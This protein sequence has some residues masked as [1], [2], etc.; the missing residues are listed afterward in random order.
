MVLRG[1]GPFLST[2]KTI[3]A[4]LQTLN[5]FHSARQR[6]I[7]YS[8]FFFLL[9]FFLNTIIIIRHCKLSIWDGFGYDTITPFHS[10]VVI[11]LSFSLK[12]LRFTSALVVNKC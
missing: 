4:I 2:L 9:N 1:S 12:Q 8:V 7:V 6:H 10:P 5:F 11:H 3:L